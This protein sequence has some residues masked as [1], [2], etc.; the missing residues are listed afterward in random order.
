MFDQFT[1]YLRKQERSAKTIRSYLSDLH[2]FALWFEQ[3]NGVPVTPQAVTPTDLREYRQ[4]MLI[5]QR[6]A[7]STIN[8]R[9]AA[10]STFLAWG[11]ETGALDDNP[12]RKVKGV[13][14]QPL[15]PQWLTKTEQGR[16]ESVS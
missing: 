12:A 15:A 10:L 7:A 16:L 4:Y 1:A 13:G 2:Q 14:K 9:L 8:R 3:T 6:L 11:V 5:T